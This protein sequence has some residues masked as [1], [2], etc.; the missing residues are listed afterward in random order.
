[1]NLIVKGAPGYDVGGVTQQIRGNLERGLPSIE[2]LDW[3]LAEISI[4]GNGPSLREKLPSGGYIAACNNAWKTLVANRVIPHFVVVADPLERNAEWFEWSSDAPVYLI[5]SRCH[6]SVFEALK[7][8]QVYI[9]HCNGD[10]EREA[11]ATG[12]LIGGGNTI[13][14]KAMEL[15]SYLGARKIDL[16]G[17]DSCYALD[18]S[19]HASPQ[20]WNDGDQPI[21][22]DVNDKM[23]ASAPWMIGQAQQFI[24][25][26]RANRLRYQVTVRD[27]GMLDAM[28]E[29]H[30]L[31]MVYCLDHAP[32]SWDFIAW[33]MNV[34]CYMEASGHA[35]LRVTFKSGDRTGFAEGEHIPLEPKR[36]EDLM[37]NVIRP[38]LKLFGAIEGHLEMPHDKAFPYVVAPTAKHYEE[39]GSLPRFCASDEALEWAEAYAGSYI[40][41]LREAAHWPNRNSNLSVWIEF[42]KRL[43]GR[44]IFVRDTAFIGQEIEGFETCDLASTSLD[45]R[46]ALYTAAKHNFFVSNGPATLCLYSEDIP[47]TCF[48]KSPENYP[49]HRPDWVEQHMGIPYGGQYPW[50]S[51]DQ[52]MIWADDS[53]D[54][55]IAALP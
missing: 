18:G 36:R 48:M 7:N 11:G 45:H 55:L 27:G 32:A 10:E 30:T 40:I 17:C 33:M 3:P 42:A 1:M 14:L 9:W 6:S 29:D 37:A 16:Y 13:A 38:A 20:S 8:R 35:R 28:L 54:N 15:F 47:Y 2:E 22:V 46:L 26:V 50:A 52:R 5:A 51:G 44:V 39:G 34:H 43:D 41:T 25:N 24:E 4:C 23:F 49:C 19:H 31:D 12:Q 53:L 21:P